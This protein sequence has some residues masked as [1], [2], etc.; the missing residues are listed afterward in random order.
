MSKKLYFYYSAMN[1]GKSTM[2]LQSSYNYIER[3][4]DTIIFAPEV[5]KRFGEP[6]VYSR[7]GLKQKGIGYSDTTN[8]FE[9][10]AKALE[11]KPEL[12]CILVDEAHF[13]TKRQV[14]Q[15]VEIANKLN[16]A[17]L[18]YG[19][20]SDFLGEPFEGSRYLLAWAEELVEI[21]T[22]CHCGRK[23]TM[24]L[25]VDE[26]G[27]AITKGSQVQVLGTAKYVSVCMKHFMDK[28]PEFDK[29][30]FESFATEESLS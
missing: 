29:I 16:I 6:T 26:K 20:R 19:L 18:T 9:Y 28:N 24:N 13:L 17:V 27:E 8:L 22:I 14:A 30:A 15:L 21:K 25:R 11:D 12:K 2:L 7:I 10:A 3:G 1:A 4:M 5:D 23:A